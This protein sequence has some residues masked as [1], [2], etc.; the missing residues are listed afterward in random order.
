[1]MKKT[2]FKKLMVLCTS[3][4]LAFGTVPA[5]A[6]DVVPQAVTVETVSAQAAETREK[7]EGQKSGKITGQGDQGSE[8]YKENNGQAEITEAV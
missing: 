1:M 2:I 3:A 4:A 6:A 7:P 8:I 5:G